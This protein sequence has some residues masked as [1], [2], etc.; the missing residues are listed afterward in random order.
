MLRCDGPWS[1]K[2][3]PQPQLQTAAPASAFLAQQT[4]YT[5]QHH[6][7]TINHYYTLPRYP[8]AHGPDIAADAPAPSTPIAPAVSR[9][10]IRRPSHRGVLL[11]TVPSAS[12][13]CQYGTTQATRV[14]SRHLCG[15]VVCRGGGERYVRR[16]VVLIYLF[17]AAQLFHPTLAPISPNTCRK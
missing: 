7:N 15:C 8:P 14:Q 3:A 13:Q 6:H 10:G 9:L 11:D 2:T 5:T 1:A 16:L 17:H 12:R 4:P